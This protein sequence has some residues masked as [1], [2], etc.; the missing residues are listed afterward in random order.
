MIADFANRLAEAQHIITG[1][2]W[3]V[4]PLSKEQLEKIEK[5]TA[6][7]LA[8]ELDEQTHQALIHS[9]IEGLEEYNETR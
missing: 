6:Q 9:C 4:L 5:E 2:V 8:K 7:I 3:S 1:K